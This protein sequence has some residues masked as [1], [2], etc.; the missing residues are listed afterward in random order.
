MVFCVAFIITATSSAALVYRANRVKFVQDVKV[1]CIIGN[2]S[3]FYVWH[4][5]GI[6]IDSYNDYRKV[7]DVMNAQI[8]QACGISQAELEGYIQKVAKENVQ[9]HAGCATAPPVNGGLQPLHD[10]SVLCDF[11]LGSDIPYT[12]GSTQVRENNTLGAV[13][14][15]IVDVVTVAFIFEVIRRIFFYVALGAFRPKI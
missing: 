13:E 10:A 7:P 3:T 6:P 2:Q 9:F 12:I 4:D 1:N 5:K 15:V 11:Q 8:I 14:Y